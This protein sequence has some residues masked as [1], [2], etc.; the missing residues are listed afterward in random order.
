[1]SQTAKIEKGQSVVQI[2]TRG[3]EDNWYFSEDTG[4]F[5]A[6]YLSDIGVIRKDSATLSRARSEISTGDVVALE[7]DFEKHASPPHPEMQ[8]YINGAEAGLPVRL[9]TE[10]ARKLEVYP[11]VFA[12]GDEGAP[13]CIYIYIST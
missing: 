7:V 3:F 5:S 11:A 10:S 6:W 2:N 9:S 8:M 1:M 4:G 12:A 13:L